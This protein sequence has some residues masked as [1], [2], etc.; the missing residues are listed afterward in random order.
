MKLFNNPSK[1]YSKDSSVGVILHNTNNPHIKITSE[2][3]FV[4]VAIHQQKYPQTQ[5]YSVPFEST[6]GDHQAGVLI[7]EEKE[8]VRYGIKL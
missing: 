7:H 8:R 3:H 4:G 6:D 1:V 2:D 5:L